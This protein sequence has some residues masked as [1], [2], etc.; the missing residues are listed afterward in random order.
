M[1]LNMKEY[2]CIFY[3]GALSCPNLNS[4]NL[5][6]TCCSTVLK[7]TLLLR[8]LFPSEAIKSKLLSWDNERTFQLIKTRVHWA[9]T[10]SV[11]LMLKPNTPFFVLDSSYPLKD[12]C[13]MIHTYSNS[14]SVHS[15]YATYKIWQVVRSVIGQR[16]F[17]K[18]SIGNL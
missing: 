8:P 18:L 2:H 9:L 16:S 15:G 1:H 13:G 12:Q 5:C 7:E 4:H 6:I 11:E 14:L 17:S 3:I 10:C